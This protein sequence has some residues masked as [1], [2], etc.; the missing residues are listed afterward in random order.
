MQSRQDLR[1]KGFKKAID[2]EEARRKREDQSVNIRKVKTYENLMK[3]RRELLQD[4]V[5]GTASNSQENS[6]NHAA[7]SASSSMGMGMEADGAPSLNQA[8]ARIS[9]NASSSQAQGG[10]IQGGFRDAAPAPE[11]L[12]NSDFRARIPVLVEG[13]MSEEP[14]SNLTCTQEFR[15]ALSVQQNP[16]IDVVIALGVVPRLVQFLKRDNEPQLQFEAAWALTNIASGTSAHTTTVMEHGAVPLLVR[17]L[18]SPVD[19][20]R[21]QA[22]WAL[23][24]IAGDSPRCRD[25]VLDNNVMSPLLAQITSESSVSLLRNATWALS[26][27][28]RGKPH[29]AF[30]QVQ[31][32]LPVLAHLLYSIDTEVIT[33]ATWA[34]S[35]L[36]DGSNEQIQAVIESGVTRR[37]VELLTSNNV[38]LQTPA[39]RTIGNIVTGDDLQTQVVINCNVLPCLVGLLNSPKKSIRKEACW[40]ISNVTAGNKEQIQAVINAGLVPPLVNLLTHGEFDVKKEATWALSNATSGGDPKQLLYLVQCGVIPPLCSLLDAQDAKVIKV[41]LEGLENILKVGEN[42]RQAH[43]ADVNELAMLVESCGGLDK[44]EQL[45]THQ[46]NEIYEKAVKLLEVYFHADE[47]VLDGVAPEVSGSQFAF[48][49]SQSHFPTE[50]F[51]FKN[52]NS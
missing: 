14:Q 35:Y 42:E 37:L 15:K 31:A 24:N 20:V 9:T 11:D 6:E 39:L 47:Q 18:S 22:A 32:A 46:T 51:N 23:G 3:K 4:N 13:V 16:P 10:N 7:M 40:T 48:G 25:I 34:L 33:D 30:D 1:K 52:M 26:N 19:D 2:P 17:L 41:A 28:C 12:I 38:A 43:A 44:I 27:M 29:P 5:G 50:G 45:Q 49:V 8:G 21:E 36:S